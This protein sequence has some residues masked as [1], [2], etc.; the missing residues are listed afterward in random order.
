MFKKIKDKWNKLDEGT[1]K[2]VKA[3]LVVT[4]CVGSMYL[5]ADITKAWINHKDK[6][7]FD[8]YQ[9]MMLTF[10]KDKDLGEYFLILSRHNKDDYTKRVDVAGCLLGTAD[11][12]REILKSWSDH[13]AKTENTVNEGLSECLDLITEMEQNNVNKI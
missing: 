13:L 1:K 9:R 6:H 7:K 10:D 2:A 3:G 11:K 12:T 5:G 4:A 8:D